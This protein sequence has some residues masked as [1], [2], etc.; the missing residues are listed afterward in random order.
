MMIDSIGC[1]YT[2]NEGKGIGTEVTRRGPELCRMFPG[3]FRA[4]SETSVPLQNFNSRPKVTH[5]R[6][7]SDDYPPKI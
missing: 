1:Y 2:A 3:N 4:T 7:T 5:F 6:P